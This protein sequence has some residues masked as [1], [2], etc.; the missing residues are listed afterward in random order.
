MNYT[1]STFSQRNNAMTKD[2]LMKVLDRTRK[3][4]ES[5]DQLDMWAMYADQITT[6]VEANN[7]DVDRLLSFDDFNFSHDIYGILRHSTLEGELLDC[8]WPR[9]GAVKSA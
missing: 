4:L 2:A 8:F 1:T 7:L 6:T 3:V 9:C 5:I